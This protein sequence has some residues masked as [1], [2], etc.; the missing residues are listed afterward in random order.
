M[1]NE[2]R[3]ATA[4]IER[5]TGVKQQLSE[6]IAERQ[7]ALQT[8]VG[9]R[10]ETEESL[11]AKRRAT[12]EL[13]Q[14]IDQ[15]RAE[16][17]RLRAKRESLE[18]ILSHHTYA[19]ESIRTLLGAIQ[20]HGVLA[21]FIEVSPAWEKALEEFLH[22]ELEYIVVKDWQQAE[23]S[24]D[25]LRSQLEGRATFLVE[26]A[27]AGNDAEEAAASAVDLPGFPIA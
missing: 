27:T 24:M 6:K 17:S 20:N 5:L 19:N 25:L 16:C 26:A 8:V 13:R 10:R 1:R 23:Q 15:L 2:E 14:Q 18:N 12:G 3:V 22:E 7:L 11:V 9:D 4:E 21:D